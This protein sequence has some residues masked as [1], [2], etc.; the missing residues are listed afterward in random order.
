LLENVIAKQI[1][2]FWL[3]CL[4]NII[5]FIKGIQSGSMG[6]IFLAKKF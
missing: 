2:D 1:P 5:F 6:G 3:K 4:K